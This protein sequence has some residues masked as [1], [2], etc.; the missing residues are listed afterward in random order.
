MTDF[1]PCNLCGS[2]SAQYLYSKLGIIRCSQCGLARADEI[3]D[4]GE[5]NQ[6]YSEAYFRSADSGVFGYDD[7]IRDRTKISKTFR[8]RMREIER[9]TGHKGRL[10][11][12]GCAT[13]FSLEVARERG[14]H[15]EGIEI[16]EFACGFARSTLG[17][18]ILRASLD[19]ANL[20][21][22]SFDVITM[23][24]YIE[25]CADPAN[26]F[27]HANRLLKTGGL[28]ALT[29][30]DISSVPAR[31]WGPRWMGIKQGEHMYYFSRDTIK[32]LLLRC[33]FEPVRLEHV[34]KYIDVNF[35]I[36]RASQYSSAA[37]RLLVRLSRLLGVGDRVLY[38]NPFDIMLVYGRKIDRGE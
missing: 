18:D 37:Q 29:T 16:S 10:L 30:P 15:A 7:Y 14:W 25:H 21:P 5:L 26:Q 34:G 24:D 2:Q 33:R 8:K 28:L 23:W 22:E 12:V 1:S 11:D 17:I 6:L 36:K 20:E 31:I 13:G 19:E 35:F 9:W 32:R 4:Q 3:P 38:V 27:A